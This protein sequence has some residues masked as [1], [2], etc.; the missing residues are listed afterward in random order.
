MDA[1]AWG[2]VD[3]DGDAALQTATPSSFSVPTPTTATQ[4][5]AFAVLTNA[6]LASFGKD[7]TVRGVPIPIPR[8]VAFPSRGY[9]T[10]F[11]GSPATPTPYASERC[12]EVVG[13]REGEREREGVV[14]GYEFP[15][16]PSTPAP[17]PSYTR[18]VSSPA[19][20]SPSRSTYGV[21]PQAPSTRRT[22]PS[23]SYPSSPSPKSMSAIRTVSKSSPRGKRRS[24][25]KG[26][27]P[28]LA[29]VAVS[30]SVSA[31]P[32][33]IRVPLPPFSS[34]EDEEEG[35]WVDEDEDEDGDTVIVSSLGGDADEQG[36][37]EGGDGD[38]DG[39]EDESA[40]P[41]PVPRWGFEEVLGVEV[42][43]TPV[44]VYTPRCGRET[45][46]T[47]APHYEREAAPYGGM[48]DACEREGRE[49]VQ[50]GGKRKR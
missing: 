23:P 13:S 36:E 10:P 27:F 1:A 21:V 32:T 4:T 30:V 26:L 47:P 42:D 17:A 15:S 9:E 46:P 11:P 20:S 6:H 45:T 19:S 43:V 40:L 39:D 7:D 12:W 50:V 3:R 33:P 28:C 37:E 34:V 29:S 2:D 31:T 5:H 22:P 35:D 25:V 49:E 44:P 24:P 16:T 41:T 38:G 18:S 48:R 14:T 8:P